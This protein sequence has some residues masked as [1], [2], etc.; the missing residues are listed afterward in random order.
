MVMVKNEV[1]FL[2]SKQR[3][4]LERPDSE[5][6]LLLGHTKEAIEFVVVFD[7]RHVSLLQILTFLVQT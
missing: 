7:T 3:M 5:L 2:D 4:G 6:W 1:L